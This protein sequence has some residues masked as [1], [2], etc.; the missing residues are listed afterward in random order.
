MS[1]APILTASRL[2]AGYRRGR[3]RRPV[4]SG[5]DLTIESG[6]F[7]ALLGPNGTGKS[8]LLRTLAGLQKPLA[9]TIELLGSDL[10]VLTAME[11]ARI[12]GVVLSEPV[13][14]GALSARQLVGLGRYAHTDWTGRLGPAD[15]AVVD[16][17]L[18]AV[19]ASHLAERD[20]REV[21]DGE[22]QRLNLA[23]VL[24]QEPRL[25]ILDEPTAFLDVAARVELV[26]LLHRLSRERSISVVASSHDIDLV[27]RYADTVWLI[28]RDRHLI[29]GVPEDLL[30]DG[31]I[32]AAFANERVRFV[33]GELGAITPPIALPAAEVSGPRDAARLV[34]NLLRREGFRP[35]VPGE[36][37][38]LA[39]RIG[40]DGRRWQAFHRDADISGTSFA[41][42]V[43]FLRRAST[44]EGQ[45]TTPPLAR[46]SRSKG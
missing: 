36:V 46:P 16:A 11:R 9:G 37:P 22:R 20:C 29:S 30:A 6:S 45:D 4:L 3:R 32:S 38:S 12:A 24:A 33:P 1:V 34:T 26:E 42:L 28:D 25:V 13:S 10:G 19:G 31:A 27:L 2:A 7:V 14:A 15:L 43:A 5:L 35:P 41:A 17:A 40:D 18:E 8:T 23:R 44:S 21:S 39:V